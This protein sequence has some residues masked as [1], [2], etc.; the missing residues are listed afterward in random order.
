VLAHDY[1]EILV[2]RIFKVA[3]VRIPGLVAALSAILPAD[4]D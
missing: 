1:G 3:T 4:P 2:D